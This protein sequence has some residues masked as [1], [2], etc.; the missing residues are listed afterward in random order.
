MGPE[1]FVAVR[2]ASWE[3]GAG[4]I[5]GAVWQRLGEELGGAP[6]AEGSLHCHCP[7]LC[8][9]PGAW[10]LLTRLYGAFLITWEEGY[11]HLSSEGW[12]GE[13]LAHRALQP[14]GHLG[15]AGVRYTCHSAVPWGLGL[16]ARGRRLCPGLLASPIPSAICLL[17]CWP[18]EAQGCP[19]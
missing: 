6:G 9:W 7:V 18:E 11:Y 16:G 17:L 8:A 5:R 3:E 13:V 10:S 1:P 14:L 12:V 19:K 15:Q 2:E 4:S